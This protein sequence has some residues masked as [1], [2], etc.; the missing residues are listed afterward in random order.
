MS[1]YKVRTCEVCGVEYRASYYQQRTCSRAC[2]A[3][4]NSYYDRIRKSPPPPPTCCMCGRARDV[5][6]TWRKYCS[7]QCYRRYTSERIT[8][9]YAMARA[10]GTGAATWWQ[11]LVHLVAKRD[12]TD[13][14]MC[15]Q[16]VDITLVS[17]SKGNEDGPSLDH[18]KPRSIGGTDDL[19][20]LQLTH[21]H[22]NRDAR[23]KKEKREDK[24]VFFVAP[25]P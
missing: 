2:G 23:T 10:S 22:C 1:R 8:S 20:N 6:E 14:A 16:Y 17:G 12:G 18:I 15:G 25:K 19:D 4:I 24:A 3:K 21:W 11:D 5:G 13:C 9:M 7:P